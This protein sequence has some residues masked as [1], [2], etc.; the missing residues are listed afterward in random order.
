MV[1]FQF[2]LWGMGEDNVQTKK[3]RSSPSLKV[4]TI[5]QSLL[6]APGLG[7]LLTGSL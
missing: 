7:F 1:R 4:F 5:T 2:M 3:K 6:G